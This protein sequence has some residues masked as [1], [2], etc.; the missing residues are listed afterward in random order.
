MRQSDD[1]S[2]YA[3]DPS[4]AV[5]RCAPSFVSET[6]ASSVQTDLLPEAELLTASETVTVNWWKCET[7]YLP[8]QYAQQ[9][10][11]LELFERLAA[12]DDQPRDALAQLCSDDL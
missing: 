2:P 11:L 8:E 1:S 3:Q 9:P 4:G 7:K 10:M 12:K 5:S 6:S